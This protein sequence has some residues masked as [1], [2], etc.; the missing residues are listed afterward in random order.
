MLLLV[1][2]P[3]AYGVKGVADLL[4]DRVICLPI[5]HLRHAIGVVVNHALRDAIG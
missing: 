4:N 1:R 3:L 2:W 5:R